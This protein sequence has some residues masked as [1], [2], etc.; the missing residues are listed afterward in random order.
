MARRLLPKSRVIY[1]RLAIAICALAAPLSSQTRLTLAQVNQRRPPDFAPLYENTVA[2]VQGVVNCAAMHFPE[3]TALAMDDG[4]SGA[5]LNDRLP[6]RMLDRYRPGDQIR[7]QALVS[8]RGGMAVLVPQQIELVGQKPVPPPISVPLKDL[9]NFRYEGRLV[10]TEGPI[11][12]MAQTTSGPSITLAAADTFFVFLPREQNRRGNEFASFRKGDV[13]EATGI[14]AQYC[15][16]PPY[17]RGF[18]VLAPGPESVLRKEAALEFPVAATAGG[19]LLLGLTGLIL[20]SRERRLRGHRERLRRIYQLGEDILGAA[21]AEAICK[22]IA[23]SLP[24]ILGIT[25]VHLYVHNRAAKTLEGV[26]GQPGEAVSIPLSE[27]PAGARSGAAACFHYRTLLVIPDIARSPFPTLPAQSAAPGSP[28]SLLFVPMMAQGEVIGVMELDQDDRMRDFSADEQA[29]AQHLG[30]QIGVAL[31]LLAQRTV[32]EQL[33]RTEKLAAV[34]R[35]ISGVVNELQTP[36]RSIGELA[37]ARSNAILRNPPSTICKSSPPRRSALP[38]WWRGWFLTPAP[39]SRE[40]PPGLDYR[41]AAQHDRIPGGRLESVR[42][43]PGGN[44]QPRAPVCLG[45]A[46]PTGAGVPEPV[47][48]RRTGLGG[49]PA[50]NHF[51]PHQYSG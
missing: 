19:L 8:Q 23:E 41:A 11:Q 25:R 2:L 24:S 45:L 48:A 50:Q 40:S 37:A 47:G 33:F 1:P 22:R 31:R 4:A 35:L 38:P 16:R 27:P 12:G 3:Y 15:P 18:E 43:P 51:H 29:L 9:Q 5:I 34:G 28:K 44:H 6:S 30:N 42:H 49:K 46:G 13:V 10:R 14:A 36:L 21:S 7:V 32:Q 26:A 20:W 39:S 17:N